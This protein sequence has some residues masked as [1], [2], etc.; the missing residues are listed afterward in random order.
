MLTLQEMPFLLHQT[1]ASVRLPLATRTI[2]EPWK[3]H[4]SN[5]AKLGRYQNQAI[6]PNKTKPPFMG[7]ISSVTGLL[8]RIA[9]WISEHSHAGKKCQSHAFSL[10][11]EVTRNEQET[12]CPL[13]E[14]HSDSFIQRCKIASA[15]GGCGGQR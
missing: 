4:C 5:Y 6:I 7:E 14:S 11:D 12:V 10:P 9:N 3:Q 13:V 8:L 1:L 2:K 15:W